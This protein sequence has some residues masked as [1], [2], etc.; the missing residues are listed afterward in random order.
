[1]IALRGATTLLNDEK[2]EIIS[3]TAEMLDLLILK[4]K[5][6]KE[7]L[8]F[9]LFSS[10]S[11]ITAYYPAAAARE[12]GYV[13]CALYSSLEPEITGALNKCIRVM[14]VADADRTKE[15]LKHVYLNGAKDLRKDLS[16]D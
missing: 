11:D 3:A 10:T 9:I 4:N 8:L 14:V 16:D 12:A 6:K 7:D 15:E 5:L 13:S 1:M 2:T